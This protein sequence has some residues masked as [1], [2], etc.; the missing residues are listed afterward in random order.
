MPKGFNWKNSTRC[1]CYHSWNA[2]RSRCLNP[3]NKDFHN[4]GGKGITICER[5]I[6]NYDCFYDD[7]GDPPI[8]LSL[9]RID[10]KGN[11]EPNNCRWASQK[12]QQNNRSNNII[13]TIDGIAKT[14]SEWA[15][16]KNI[17]SK[18]LRERYLTYSVPLEI[19]FDKILPS[20]SWKHG[21]NNGYNSGCRCNECKNFNRLKSQKY[22]NKIKQKALST[23]I[24]KEYHGTRTGY[25][26]YKCRCTLCRKCNAERSAKWYSKIK[27][28]KA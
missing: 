3:K 7:M 12:Q 27:L 23:P 1:R 10:T 24:K 17:C 2:M 11:Y 19:L 22:R 25:E 4:Y 9:D 5:W 26:L 15:A 8:G 14:L 6:N 18:K 16:L 28:K 20:H 21:T 13:I